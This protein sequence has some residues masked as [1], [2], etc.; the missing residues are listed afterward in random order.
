[1]IGAAHG[2]TMTER[3]AKALLALYGVPVVD[4]ALVRTRQDAARAAET[5]G[6]PVVLKLES[7]DVPHKTEAGVIRLGDQP[8]LAH[9]VAVGEASRCRYAPDRLDRG[10]RRRVRAR[11]KPAQVRLLRSLIE[12]LLPLSNHATRA[13]RAS[14]SSSCLITSLENARTSAIAASI[15]LTC[16][17]SRPLKV[18]PKLKIARYGSRS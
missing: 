9:R 2:R 17:G 12:Q 5:F 3:E 4:E 1:M 6:Y 7:P 11:R 13:R 18:P 16:F 8:K 15:P 10:R 14:I